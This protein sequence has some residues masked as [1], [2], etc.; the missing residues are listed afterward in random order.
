MSNVIITKGPEFTRDR[1]VWD[2]AVDQTTDKYWSKNFGFYTK[3]QYFDCD[4]DITS[5]NTRGKQ[6]NQQKVSK[7]YQ[8]SISFG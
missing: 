5:I 1:I 7:Q 2:T 6:K 4:M 8:T 3:A